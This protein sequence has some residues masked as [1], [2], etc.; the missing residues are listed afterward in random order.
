MEHGQTYLDAGC[1]FPSAG[2]ARAS[3]ETIANWNQA[4]SERPFSFYVS[5]TK[6]R[7]GRAAP[8]DLEFLFSECC[9]SGVAPTALRTT[10]GS[11]SHFLWSKGR[12]ASPRRPG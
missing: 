10:T 11:A 2:G 8:M 6:M 7:G 1:R 9:C 3:V 12:D 4:P 5:T